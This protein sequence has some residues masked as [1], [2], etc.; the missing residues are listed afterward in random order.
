[1]S[2]SEKVKVAIEIAADGATSALS[3]LKTDVGQADGFFG[4][5]KAG[6]KGALDMIGGAGPL[7]AAGVTAL[8]GAALKG[9]S[10]FAELGQEVGKFKDVTGMSAEQSSRWKEVLGDLGVDA[11][12]AAGIINKMNTNIGK[13]EKA[14]KDAGVEVVRMKDGTVDANATFL[15]VIDTLHNTD[16]QTKKAA[17]A[18]KLL[19]KSWTDASELISM[20]ADEV[21]KSLASVAD[22]QIVDDKDIKDSRDFR[23][24]MD[25]LQDAAGN[26]FL[27]LGKALLPI[28]NKVVP[29][30]AEIVESIEPVVEAVGE[31]LGQAFEALLPIVKA[32]TKILIP[33]VETILAV[34]N[35]LTGLIGGM[36]SGASQIPEFANAMKILEI[37]ETLTAAATNA[38]TAATNALVTAALEQAKSALEQEKSLAILNS[39]TDE[40][41]DRAEYYASRV[42]EAK[43]EQDGS[44]DRAE[45][46]ASRINAVKDASR[47]A[48]AAQVKMKWA[49]GEAE[50][51]FNDLKDA[52]DRL[53][54]SL[55]LEESYQSL[56]L[57][58]DDVIAANVDLAEQVADGSIDTETAMRKE[59][60]NWIGLKQDVIA[61]GEQIGLTPTDITTLVNLIDNGDIDAMETKLD[62][63][64]K[65]RK[66]NVSLEAKGLS[67]LTISATTSSR[68]ASGTSNFQGGFTSVNE[69]GDEVIGLPDGSKIFTANQ[70]KALLAG[71]GS[72]TYNDNRVT[73]VY[74]P[75]E[76]G[77]AAY[78]KVV[79]RNY[80]LGGGRD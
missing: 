14:F 11:N 44:A 70:S 66:I 78:N 15:N 51:K 64:T 4:K 29:V 12:A 13:N 77:I 27:V 10:D 61:Y 50:R 26:L 72:G 36:L 6:G 2:F 59:S 80:K 42:A 32:A 71:A 37:Q 54:G 18:Q 40:A 31:S 52:L 62:E 60:L 56:K 1:M 53:K 24:A 49:A 25:G 73:N 48:A 45:Y 22:A 43:A 35:A 69:Q 9:V 57:S 67:G 19:G 63:L 75:P 30:F 16:D 55:S 76:I 47:E 23:D 7:A 58:I 8:A 34:N 33:L 68:H 21:G 17:I 41:A 20:G 28:I 3:K 5:L 46:Y 39:K 38:H 79:K 65:D 74:M